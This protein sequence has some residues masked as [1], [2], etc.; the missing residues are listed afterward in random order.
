MIHLELLWTFL[1]I[2]IFSFGGAYGSIPLIRDI[3]LSQ[4]WISEDM[5]IYFLAVS[6]STPGPIMI[7]LATYI[8]SSTAGFWGAILAT[9]GVVVPSFV[10]ILVITIFMKSFINNKH[11]QAILSGIKPGF[12]GLI[13]AMGIYMII[14]D[15]VMSIKQDIIEWQTLFIIVILLTLA[16]GYRYIKKKDFP[17]ILLIIL[18]AC[19]GVIMYSFT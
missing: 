8:G 11:I 9:I 1:K 3:V 4:G 13:L 10:V 14:T 17:P 7:N 15:I 19:I 16:F 12:I 5:F 2:G 6:E 18:S